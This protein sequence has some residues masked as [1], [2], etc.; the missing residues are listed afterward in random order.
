MIPFLAKGGKKG[1][2]SPRKFNSSHECVRD[3]R[4]G[5]EPDGLSDTLEPLF[6]S[7]LSQIPPPRVSMTA[8]LQMLVT[9]IDY[10]DF[11]GRVAIGRIR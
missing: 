5:L 6:D 4:A 1:Q 7:I 2:G 11:K 8:P 10:D 9:N 3:I